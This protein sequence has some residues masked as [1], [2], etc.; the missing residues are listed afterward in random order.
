VPQLDVLDVLRPDQRKAGDRLRTGGTGDC[1]RAF[2]N[3]SARCVDLRSALILESSFMDTVS[4]VSMRLLMIGLP[5][6][7]ESLGCDARG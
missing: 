6:A 2:Q 5:I 3:R 1:R 4:G 7:R